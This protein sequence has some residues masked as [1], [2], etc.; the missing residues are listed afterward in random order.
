MPLIFLVSDVTHV[1]RWG[2][3]FVCILGGVGV[4]AKGNSIYFFFRY[5]GARTPHQRS[6]LGKLRLMPRADIQD[7]CAPVAGRDVS[8]TPRGW[9]P[10]LGK[11]QVTGASSPAAPPSV[12]DPSPQCPQHPRALAR[13]PEWLWL[14]MTGCGKNVRKLVNGRAACN[15]HLL[16]PERKHKYKL[17]TQKIMAKDTFL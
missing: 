8:S 4:F 9:R 2:I 6:T 15:S 12:L 10:D 5:G 14:W 1:P 16:L 11:G 13:G 17:L 7:L 3:L